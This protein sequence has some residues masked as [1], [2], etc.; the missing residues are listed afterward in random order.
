MDESAYLDYPDNGGMVWHWN[1]ATYA[2]PVLNRDGL[3]TYV[4]TADYLGE[5][6]IAHVRAAISGYRL[7][8][9][10]FIRIPDS[11]LYWFDMKNKYP[12]F[13]P[14]RQFAEADTIVIAVPAGI[15]PSRHHSNSTSN[16]SA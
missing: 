1:G 4:D 11:Q 16:R 9:G 8:D 7:E 2:N 14:A 6:G 12:M 5:T 15:T 10:T 13:A 3:I